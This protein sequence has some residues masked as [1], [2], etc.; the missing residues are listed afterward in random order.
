MKT[1]RKTL[2]GLF[3][4][5]AV[6][7]TTNASAQLP[8][9][10]YDS[11]PAWTSTA[12]S[13]AVDEGSAGKY[14]FAGTQFRFLGANVSSTSYANNIPLV[15]PITV[16]CNVT[17]MYDYVP[18]KQGDLIPIPA[19]WKSVS[20]NAMVVGYKDPDGMGAAARVT[21]I[22]KRVNRATQG[23]S[24]IITFDSNTAVD[25]VATEGVK[26]FTHTFDF[27]N[28]EYYVELNLVRTGTAVATPIAYSVRLTKGGVQAI[29]R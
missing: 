25:N 27:K 2:I 17:P 24:T 4:A 21:A 16:R 10:W 1:I 18:A 7:M 5:G 13:C 20:W 28:Y 11:L 22:L 26:T 14:E 8:T 6:I 19:Y 29:P 3:G 15:Q 12:S 23:E 9:G